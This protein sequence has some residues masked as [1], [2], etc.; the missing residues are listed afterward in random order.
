MKGTTEL[1]RSFVLEVAR[2]GGFTSLVTAG[3][4]QRNCYQCMNFGCDASPGSDSCNRVVPAEISGLVDFTRTSL[5]DCNARQSRV[6]QNGAVPSSGGGSD[7]TARLRDEETFG[8]AFHGPH[9]LRRL[10][11]NG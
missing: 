11:R 3:L 7:S 4:P 1:E 5:S 6:A 2:H 9:T 8:T 10:T